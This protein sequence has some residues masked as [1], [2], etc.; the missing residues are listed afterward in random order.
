MKWFTKKYRPHRAHKRGF[1]F[2]TLL[3]SLGIGKKRHHKHISKSGVSPV[4]VQPQQKKHHKSKH[5][6]RGFYFIMRLFKRRPHRKSRSSYTIIQELERHPIPVPREGKYN[7]FGHEKPSGRRSG[8]HKRTARP[9]KNYE[10]RE[11]LKIRWTRAWQN[12]FY[13]LNL[14]SQPYDSFMRD[15]NDINA[16]K[17]VM[18]IRKI[19]VYIF[20]STVL[21][22]IS[23]IVAYITYQL[24]VIFVASFFG[25]DSVLYYY[26][27]LFPI[28]NYGSLWTRFN[29]IMITISGPLVSLILGLVYF[30]FFLRREGIGPMAK[31]FFWWLSFHSFSMFFGAYV[32]GVITV[33][34]FG[35][36]T[37][38][39]FL[40][41]FIKFLVALGSL[42]VL[43]VIGYY[44]T[45]P[46]LETSNSLRHIIRGNR[47]YFILTQAV[48]P[49]FLGSLI[50]FLIKIPDKNPQHEN[51]IVYD[52]III[53]SLVF[54]IIPTFFNKKAKPRNKLFKSRKRMKFVWVYMLVAILLIVAYR[55]GL[56]NGLHFVIRILVNITPYG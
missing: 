55:L 8:K 17:Q 56:D 18:P 38:W 33:Q 25:I 37:G 30:R 6:H 45:K 7:E 14:R 40:P 42:F 34:G 27:V 39:L 43:M 12:A 49:W 21:F 53:A 20:N 3:R 52:L 51:I 48:V 16:K 9:S 41:V 47:G 24:I 13:F 50:L 26:E 4:V 36:A 5:K 46:L 28:G 54:A 2:K 10:K 15:P 11:G 31:L 19:A 35:F 32:A 44:A 29:I 22:L 23:Y 1:F